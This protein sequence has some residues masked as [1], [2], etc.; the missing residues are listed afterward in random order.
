[1]FA[2]AVLRSKSTTQVLLVPEQAVSLYQGHPAVFIEAN[3]GFTPR[4]VEAGPAI[5]GKVTI[6]AGVAPGERIVVAGAYALKA[7][8]LKSQFATED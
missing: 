3:G 6:K 4:A 7:R 8:L 2:S 5:G 1:M